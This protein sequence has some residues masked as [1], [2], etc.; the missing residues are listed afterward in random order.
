MHERHIGVHDNHYEEIKVLREELNKKH[1]ELLER[2]V[3]VETELKNQRELIKAFMESVDKRFEAVDK[4]FDS[5]D[6]RFE[7]LTKYVDKRIGTLEKLMFAFNVP[8]LLGIMLLLWK[9][10]IMP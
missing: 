2:I 6:K 1:I 10:F 4:R 8:M 5:M 3:R 9:V 7:E